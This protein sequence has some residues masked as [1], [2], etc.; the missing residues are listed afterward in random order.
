MKNCN[1]RGYPVQVALI[2]ETQKLPTTT[3]RIKPQNSV[4]S[5]VFLKLLFLMT[6]PNVAPR[7][8]PCVLENIKNAVGN[9]GRLYLMEVWSGLWSGGP[10]KT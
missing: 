6:V 8:G 7:I 3:E 5:P 1:T 2:N 10:A 9:T 4:F